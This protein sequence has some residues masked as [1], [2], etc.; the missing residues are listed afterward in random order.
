M[1]N[2]WPLIPFLTFVMILTHAC[3][4]QEAFSDPP[5]D[6]QESDLV[7]TWEAHYDGSGTG[8]DRLILKGDGTF[9]QTYDSLS[10]HTF[11]TSWN[12]WHIERFPD[13]GRI[14][15]YLEGARF[16]DEGR[17]VAEEEGIACPASQCLEDMPNPFRDPV[18]DNYVEMIGRLVL[19]VRTSPDT[20]GG[21]VL[22]HMRLGVDDL[23]SG[24]FFFVEEP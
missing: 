8:V 16:Y 19:S 2:K 9:Q 7:G 18:Y 13:D 17:R 15:I 12:K 1:R 5:L 24:T 14:Y 11:E 4:G 6:L 20:P 21:L 10:G 3:V 22:K 23:R